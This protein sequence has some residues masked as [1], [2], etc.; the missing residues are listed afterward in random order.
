MARRLGIEIQPTTST[1]TSASGS[2]I[3]LTG[4]CV[5]RM[6]NNGRE[7]DVECLIAKDLASTMLLSW[8]D[9]KN[10]GYIK[11]LFPDV[12]TVQQATVI[13]KDSVE[14]LCDDFPHVLTDEFNANEDGI[15]G[16]KMHIN[17]RDDCKIVPTHVKSSRGIPH[18]LMSP[19][20]NLIDG[21]LNKGMIDEVPHTKVTEWCSPGH[22]VVKP[23]TEDRP[24]D[25]RLVTD[26]SG[27]NRY[28]KRPVHLFESPRD[29]L[30]RIPPEA[31][32]FAKFD[33][34]HG[35]F[36]IP[37]DE[38]SKDLTTFLLPFGR[39]RYNVAPQGANASSDVFLKATDAAVA[40]LLWLLKM[41]DDILIWAETKSQLF[42][43]I[44]IFLKRCETANL[45]MSRKKFKIGQDIKFVGYRVTQNGIRPDHDKIAGI[46]KFKTPTNVTEL[47]SFLGLAQ[48][49]GFFLPD[50]SQATSAMRTLLKK[51]TAWLWTP[52]IDLEFHKAKEILTSDAIVKPFDP[53]LEIV[54]LTDAAR[55][56][57]MG[58]AL[59]QY[60]DK[61]DEDGKQR[62]RLVSCNSKAFTATQQRYATIE[63]E[64]LA[65]KWAVLDLEFY[66]LGA[67]QVKVLTDHHPLLGVFRKPLH[68]ITN[69]RLLKYREALIHM[70][71]V[72]E[73]V[74]G[75]DHLIADALSR[76]PVFL[77]HEEN[78]P[79]IE[80]VNMALAFNEDLIYSFLFDCADE[81][82]EKLAEAIESGDIPKKGPF[83][84]MWHDLSVLRRKADEKPLIL[85][86]GR[87][88][89][90]PKSQRR[91]I[92]KS[93]HRSHAGEVKTLRTARTSYFWPGM[94]N[95]V[96]QLLR[97][98]SPCQEL[99]PS[100]SNEPS[101]VEPMGQADA[102]MVAL[103]ADLFY[104]EGHHYLL[105]VDR[106]SGY[107]WVRYLSSLSAVGITNKIKSIVMEYGIP[108]SIRT[109][110]GPQ[111]QGF[112]PDFCKLYKI[113]HEVSSP[114]NPQSNGLAEAGVKQAKY[115]LMKTKKT[116]EDFSLALLAMNATARNDGF[117]PAEAFFGRQVNAGWPFVRRDFDP[118]AFWKLRSATRQRQLDQMD[119]RS[120]TL[121][122]L[123]LEDPVLMQDSND[124]W[125]INGTIKKIYDSGRSYDVELLNGS[126]MRRN[127]RFLRLDRSSPEDFAEQESE[128][129]AENE[130][131]PRRSARL[132]EKAL[133][134]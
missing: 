28:V 21:L 6:R 128:I 44:R 30:R 81:E 12:A 17:L 70:N 50:L 62:L 60:P 66:L 64:C 40:D 23:A 76:S 20:K 74:P 75:K 54:L 102:P 27:L 7:E 95:E 99:R 124:R 35:Y 91:E 52:E 15:K 46:A 10:F 97:N 2:G 16:P 36:Q 110:G 72:L 82:T 108:F 41:V 55:L 112:F 120:K 134:K 92:L 116:H 71:L 13:E 105:L 129:P 4:E 22:F 32:W 37:L 88:I 109:D 5:L 11:E 26:F 18:H 133:R 31:K 119:K 96:R 127:R 78:D 83:R 85:H 100:Q 73:W 65:I 123:N 51:N 117:S 94:A 118:V 43:R 29:L 34:L 115:L 121:E 63:L 56:H 101:M 59:C 111:F 79:V 24:L 1:L 38:E 48:Q 49:L 104:W 107:I 106:F 25:A 68:E 19:A 53:K 103:G 67:D 47:K 42:E 8:H 57:G 45:K 113:K 69:S 131:Q 61:R 33:C 14:K 39:F 3:K 93:L 90:V 86:D 58:Y 77:A 125:T 114:H 126:T 122:D 87:R 130:A 132:A 80:Q 9:M 89:F 84:G 98:C